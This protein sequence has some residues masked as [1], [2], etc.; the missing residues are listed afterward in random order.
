MGDTTTTNIPTRINQ[1]LDTSQHGT[2]SGTAHATID[3]H[4]CIWMTSETVNRRCAEIGRIGGP[5]DAIFG[6]ATLQG[7]N[8]FGLTIEPRRDILRVCRHVDVLQEVHGGK[9]YIDRAH[10]FV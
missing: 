7:T 9:T 2:L 3:I 1:G 6:W 10:V 5:P 8:G 4:L